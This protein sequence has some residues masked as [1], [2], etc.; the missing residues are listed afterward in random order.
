[1]SSLLRISISMVIPISI[2]ALRQ[3]LFLSDCL[4]YFDFKS[5]VIIST[6]KDQALQSVS[7]ISLETSTLLISYTVGQEEAE[8]AQ[9]IL[10][11]KDLNEIDA[12]LFLDEG[13]HILLKKLIMQLNLFNNEVTGIISV[14]DIPSENSALRLDSKFYLHQK[15][16]EIIVL[17][18][19]Y[20]INGVNIL[21]DIGNWQQSVGLNISQ[22]NIW[23][24]RNNLAGMTVRV[25]TISIPNV[26]EL[27]YDDSE[28]TIIGAG[29]F[30]IEPL[31]DM[32]RDFNFSL[33]FTPP[34]DGNWGAIS[35]NGT[36]NGMVGMLV[37]GRADIV[38]AQLSRTIER[39]R[40]ISFSITLKE[41]VATLAT[42]F[43]SG[44]VPQFWIYVELL[45]ITAWVACFAMVIGIACGFTIINTAGMNHLHDDCSHDFNIIHGIGVSLM[46]LRQ[47]YYDINTEVTSSRILFL[48]SGIA[49]YLIYTHYTAYLT[50]RT[51]S[52]S[53]ESEIKSFEDVIRGGFKVITLES[54]SSREFLKTSKPGTAMHEVYYG[55]MHNNPS[56]FIKSLEEVGKQMH[57]D[58]KT[59]YFGGA[60]PSYGDGVK[61]LQIQG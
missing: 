32:A 11:L 5:P 1:M 36:W 56:A 44:M 14:S 55:S 37:E 22:P 13:H 47:I 17:K 18:E 52:G 16:S 29:G 25:T 54:G 10:R 48:V 58:A 38:A 43:T 40:A 12:I 61:F 59:L 19:M 53:H 24:R 50:A 60:M 41:E 45:P 33:T 51:T 15:E 31:N 8:V 46:F 35:G 42:P 30:F 57:D 2:G 49:T 26:H 34:P 6:D 23:E 27:Y 7:A 3:S 20:A 39:S 21:N 28:D 4:H 9:Y